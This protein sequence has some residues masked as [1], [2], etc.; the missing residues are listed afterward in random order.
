MLAYKNLNK[1]VNYL[2]FYTIIMIVIFVYPKNLTNRFQS[3]ES[4]N[5]YTPKSKRSNIEERWYRLT[6][7]LN[8]KLERWIR[9][10]HEYWG[11]TRKLR[12]LRKATNESRWLLEGRSNKYPKSHKY[13]S[14][15]TMKR[16][17]PIAI[18]S[19]LA[20]Q[21]K[22]SGPSVARTATFD[23]DSYEI[24]VDNR[25]SGCISN[26]IDDFIGDMR[27]S[28]RS[29]KSF[30]GSK[31]ANVKIG[32]LQW[33]WMNNG[34]KVHNFVIPNSFYVPEGG[35]RLLSPQHWAKAI[36]GR[37]RKR[38]NGAGSETLSDKVTLF[39]DNRRYKLTIPLCKR[40]NVATLRSAPSNKSF[41]AFCQ[42]AEIDYDESIKDPIIIKPAT[43]IKYDE[44]G[45]STSQSDK[46]SHKTKSRWP[47]DDESAEFNIQGPKPSSSEDEMT[48]QHDLTLKA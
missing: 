28:K 17:I 13:G 3:N 37:N 20:M 16:I 24:G 15:R 47:S 4:T 5:Q 42:S 14:K 12:R 33:K 41:T 10:S 11:N 26:N 9:K 43:E 21:T 25:C 31:T 29:I 23:T 30:G 39:W 19:A 8:L 7:V 36:N 27:D 2:L 44:E 22:A 38:V 46:T 35:V 40:T 1:I 18:M 45:H 48:S 34:G 32:T 6:K